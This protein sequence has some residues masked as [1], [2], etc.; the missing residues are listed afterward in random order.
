VT[1]I[2]RATVD[3]AEGI[4]AVHV[5]SAQAAYRGIMP[6]AYLDSLDPCRRSEQWQQ[7]LA[8]G[9]QIGWT[10]SGSGETLVLVAEDSS[11]RIVGI[12]ALGAERGGRDPAVGELHMINLA[13][14]VWGR[15]VGT[16]LLRS[17]EHELRQLGFQQAVLWVLE[18]NSRARRFY[19]REGWSLDGA[20][21]EEHRPGFT[22]H[23]VRYRRRL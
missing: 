11:G 12:A 5:A 13:P 22:L 8:S 3:D 10:R 7:A 21:K 14:Q 15:G 6:D 2:R 19:E 1:T 4:G 9:R 16:A 20:V 18:G 23:E 17:C